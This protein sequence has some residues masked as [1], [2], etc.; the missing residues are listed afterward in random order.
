MTKFAHLRATLRMAIIL[1]LCGGAAAQQ[2]I[3]IQGS[4]A[5]IYMG[6]RLAEIY[7]RIAQFEG[8]R[9]ALD[10]SDFV[11]FPI[12]VQTIVVYVNNS[13]PV[14]NLTMAQLQSIFWERPP[15]GRA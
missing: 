13:N 4:D 14:K 2:P 15:I 5:L 7:Q 9:G 12:G 11:A 10:N 1:C 8:S 3:S 6:Q